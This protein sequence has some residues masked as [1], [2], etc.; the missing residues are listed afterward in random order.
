MLTRSY[1]YSLHW[2]VMIVRPPDSLPQRRLET[3]PASRNRTA[4]PAA[5]YPRTTRPVP[6]NT[7][8]VNM[9]FS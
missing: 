3:A 1:L 2:V 9:F 7:S 5:A 8:S 6:F 4:A